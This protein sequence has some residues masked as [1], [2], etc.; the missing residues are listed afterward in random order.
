[1]RRANAVCVFVLVLFYSIIGRAE[2]TAKID[3]VFP[4][5]I[6]SRALVE[7][8]QFGDRLYDVFGCVFTIINPN[9]VSTILNLRAFD[10][11][12]VEIGLPAGRNQIVVNPGTAMEVAGLNLR[13]NFIGWLRI[14]AT[15]PVIVQESIEHSL[16]SDNPS[17][18]HITSVLKSRVTKY[19]TMPARRQVTKVA[20]SLGVTRAQQTGISIVYPANPTA[21]AAKGTLILR[22]QEGAVLGQ[23]LLSLPPNGQVVALFQEL[24]PAVEFS[25]IF[26]GSFQVNFD[27]SVAVT[28]VQVTLDRGQEILEEPAGGA[29]PNDTTSQ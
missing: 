27:Q 21:P 13:D 5:A 26:S 7:T 22:N 3:M 18:P 4:L 10:A 9:A 29:I 28:G 1:M 23:R 11:N 24:F 8:N 16:V 20:F 14:S 25:T 12:G 6:S 15:L 2:D 17:I 19:S